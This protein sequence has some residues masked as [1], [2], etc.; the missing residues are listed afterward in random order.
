MNLLER[1]SSGSPP[2]AFGVPYDSFR[3]QPVSAEADG[4]PEINPSA[5]LGLDIKSRELDY[6]FYCFFL[7]SQRLD[8]Y[9]SLDY[10]CEDMLLGMII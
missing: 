3:K 2:S 6:E 7:S 4:S 9:K 1:Q 8:L 5:D 10:R